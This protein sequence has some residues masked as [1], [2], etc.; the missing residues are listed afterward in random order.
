MSL[1]SRRSARQNGMVLV[2]ALLMLIVVTIIAL[3][4]FRSFGV[5]E[6]IAGNLREKQR[7]V[8]AAETAE[9]YAEYWLANGGNANTVPG[10][11]SSASTAVGP[12]TPGQICTNGLVTP[13]VLPWTAGGNVVGVTY[14]PS[15]PTVGNPTSS[16]P[17][18]I[19]GLG[20]G[21]GNYYSSPQFYITFLGATTTQGSIYQI[22]AVGYGGSPDTA[23]VVESTYKV[24]TNVQCLSCTP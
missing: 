5:D 11:C 23:A 16:S 21:Q 17:M 8:S 22:D 2:T 7:A 9:Q 19:T 14:T 18:S 20:A 6:K 3:A 1:H 12:T 10:A 15:A 24:Q 4:M 13:A